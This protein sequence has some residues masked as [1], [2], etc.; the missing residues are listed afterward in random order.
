MSD[1]TT[2]TAADIDGFL[3]DLQITLATV[4]SAMDNINA[5]MDPEMVVPH[6]T[7]TQR[8]AQNVQASAPTWVDNASAAAAATPQPTDLP[9]ATADESEEEDSTG[10]DTVEPSNDDPRSP[11]GPLGPPVG[12]LGFPARAMPTEYDRD[13]LL[14]TGGLDLSVQEIYQIR[15]SVYRRFPKRRRA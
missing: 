7:P 3:H 1:S 12:P 6:S 8:H 13:M 5:Q 11:V 15:C 2:I 9:Q 10:S 14:L 4:N